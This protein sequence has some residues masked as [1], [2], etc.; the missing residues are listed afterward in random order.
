M[1]LVA[2]IVHFFASMS[3]AYV[4]RLNVPEVIVHDRNSLYSKNEIQPVEKLES[5]LPPDLIEEKNI[6]TAKQK[7][8]QDSKPYEK[9]AKKHGSDLM[10]RAKSKQQR[11]MHRK[12]HKNRKETKKIKAKI[13]NPEMFWLNRNEEKNFENTRL[14][15]VDKDQGVENRFLLGNTF[16]SFVSG[17]NPLTRSGI[18]EQSDEASKGDLNTSNGHKSLTDRV[19]QVEKSN[20][21]I[22]V[23]ENSIV[24]EDDLKS[25]QGGR[26][27]VRMITDTSSNTEKTSSFKSSESKNASAENNENE[28]KINDTNTKLDFDGKGAE[29]NDS[30]VE[31]QGKFDTKEE[32]IDNIE[33]YDSAT[34]ELIPVN[35][36]SISNVDV[37]VKAKPGLNKESKTPNDIQNALA[38]NDES[39]TEKEVFT[40]SGDSSLHG[41]EANDNKTGSLQGFQEEN[42]DDNEY[43]DPSTEEVIDL[44]LFN[45]TT[46]NEEKVVKNQNTPGNRFGSSNDSKITTGSS[47]EN[48]ETVSAQVVNRTK[49]ASSSNN[50]LQ[51]KQSTDND[52]GEFTSKSNRTGIVQQEQPKS[53]ANEEER[54]SLLDNGDKS[55]DQFNGKPT[56]PIT[57]GSEFGQGDEFSG[58]DT[59]LDANHQSAKG[60]NGS[61]VSL[62]NKFSLE[63][64]LT[65]D[66][67]QGELRSVEKTGKRNNE[68]KEYA[69]SGIFRQ[70]EEERGKLLRE[71]QSV[72]DNDY[73]ENKELNALAEKEELDESNSD[74]LDAF[75]SKDT[76]TNPDISENQNVTNDNKAEENGKES[77]EQTAKSE[78]KSSEHQEHAEAFQ[79]KTDNEKEDPGEQNASK[80]TE[81]VT[82]RNDS[83]KELMTDE[84]SKPGS[85]LQMG[86][87]SNNSA[88]INQD[89]TES[90]TKVTWKPE[91]GILPSSEL[92]DSTLENDSSKQS[93]FE[94]GQDLPDA[95]ASDAT[96][97]I[98]ESPT[99][100][101]KSNTTVNEGP[102]KGAKKT[103]K[104]NSRK[105]KNAVEKTRSTASEQKDDISVV[106][107]KINIAQ[108]L[109]NEPL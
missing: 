82:E 61:V 103:M 10:R 65:T 106:N 4:L 18:G 51:E 26:A 27:N 54:D 66:G 63:G 105:L 104:A 29:F 85:N 30:S 44:A 47:S 107:A 45:D 14:P 35:N 25:A 96:P 52:A 37:N 94:V 108:Q 71:A 55:T 75:N 59:T 58:G 100:T 84:E 87:L 43:V 7:R 91:K 12:G 90:S 42:V 46:G 76:A 49:D 101:S 62:N 92:K 19:N 9:K 21:I 33:T 31:K 22:K 13:E 50:S 95:D 1:L 24:K 32:D 53:T 79:V 20:I 109:Y 64:N 41:D 28:K 73:K 78:G 77:K 11:K 39:K 97:T 38:N 40:F 86:E 34:E 72:F 102:N 89:R 3:S 67:S 56:P 36:A 57:L 81:K 80:N 68:T 15:L 83:A 6:E 70:I 16:D 23:G 17:V 8:E 88:T 98:T 69:V 74:E 2:V 99:L 48:T 93:V 5:L 60:Q